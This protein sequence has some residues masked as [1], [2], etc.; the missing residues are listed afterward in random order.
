MVV[1]NTNGVWDNQAMV[2]RVDAVVQVCVCVQIA[3]H[4]VLPC[5]HGKHGNEY[6]E[7]LKEHWRLR[8][9]PGLFQARGYLHNE[10]I[11][12]QGKV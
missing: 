5:V 12:H 9:C 11:I 2:V 7:E 10:R 4:K 3:V 1:E 6:L 8:Y